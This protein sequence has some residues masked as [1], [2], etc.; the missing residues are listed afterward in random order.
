MHTKQAQVS[1]YQ[2][3]NLSLANQTVD[4]LDRLDR[5]KELPFDPLKPIQKSSPLV[6]RVV[7]PA[8]DRIALGET[9]F[10][11]PA[12]SAIDVR[13]EA[14]KKSSSHETLD[15]FVY[16]FR[17]ANSRSAALRNIEPWRAESELKFAQN[18]KRAAESGRYLDEETRLRTIE[19]AEARLA[20]AQIAA[21]AAGPTK[22]AQ[23]VRCLRDYAVAIS[24]HLSDLADSQEHARAARHLAVDLELMV[25]AVKNLEKG[26]AGD[27]PQVNLVEPFD[28]VA[29]IAKVRDHLEEK[30]SRINS[31]Q[32]KRL[33]R[34]VEQNSILTQLQNRLPELP[35]DGVIFFFS[36][37]G[38]IIKTPM[39]KPGN[40]L[41]GVDRQE[42]PKSKLRPDGTFLSPNGE[43]VKV[44]MTYK[45]IDVPRWKNAGNGPNGAGID[46]FAG[47]D[48]AGAVIVR[49]KAGAKPIQANKR[50]FV[51]KEVV[52]LIGELPA[53]VIEGMAF[54]ELA[55]RFGNMEY[56]R[57]PSEVK[58]V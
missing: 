55:K 19:I 45:A 28:Y 8:V 58:A 14:A 51:E 18:S 29:R 36:R 39:S 40:I 25:R 44:E 1:D 54:K 16:E 49:P 27:L 33:D 6:R 32:D 3:Q 5:R 26:G 41:V 15:E 47:D 37:E 7:R 56:S 46:R 11:P 38:L 13:G 22:Y 53:D 35:G 23:T 20:K 57:K 42:Y 30:I 17:L 43:T 48:I 50:V 31:N 2:S 10:A 12:D 21:D 52:G 4:L 34:L 9:N 24:K